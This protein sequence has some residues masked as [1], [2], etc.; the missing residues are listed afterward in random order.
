MDHLRRLIGRHMLGR[1]S[2]DNV[3]QMALLSVRHHDEQLKKMLKSNLI[4]HLESVQDS[5][6]FEAL[7]VEAPEFV[8][9]L[10]ATANGLNAAI[11]H[12]TH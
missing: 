9:R 2:S 12:A 10:R 4:T 1:V 7:C 5:E 8:S 3:C 6:Y 11:L